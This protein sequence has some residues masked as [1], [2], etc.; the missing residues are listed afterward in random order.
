MAG[1]GGGIQQVFLRDRYGDG[2]FG[3]SFCVLT[4]NSTGLPGRVTLS[5]SQELALN[6]LTVS[7]EDLPEE[8]FGFFLTSQT[9]AFLISTGTPLGQLCLTWQIGRF[10][11]PGEV[12]STGASGSISIAPDLTS[13]PSPTGFVPA[14]A[15]QTWAFQAWTRDSFGGQ[16]TSIFTDAIGVT[17]R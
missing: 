11:G 16:A 3:T 14:A 6:S 4:P 17:L 1:L 15:G 10:V 5:G 9:S 7:A 13:M 2:G 12:Q 8:T